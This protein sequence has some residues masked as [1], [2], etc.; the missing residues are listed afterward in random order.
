MGHFVSFAVL[1]L[2]SFSPGEILKPILIVICNSCLWLEIVKHLQ[3]E[4]YSIKYTSY[5]NVLNGIITGQIDD[6]FLRK[7]GLSL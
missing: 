2:R 4:Y 1:W 6:F 5:S 3:F 7:E